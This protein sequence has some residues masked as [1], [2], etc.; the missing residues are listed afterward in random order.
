M[1]LFTRF[2]KGTLIVY[3]THH[4]NDSS[5]SCHIKLPLLPHLKNTPDTNERNKNF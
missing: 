4:R 2:D 5:S 3:Y 1:C